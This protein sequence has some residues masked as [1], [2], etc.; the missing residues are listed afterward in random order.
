MQINRF[1]ED[2]LYGKDFID[3]VHVKDGGVTKSHVRRWKLLQELQ[4]SQN[5][6]SM[7]LGQ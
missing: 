1:L 6:D 7:T 3:P 4:V 2:Y 5:L